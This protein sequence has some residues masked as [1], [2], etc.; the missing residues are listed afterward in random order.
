MIINRLFTLIL[1]SGQVVMAQTQIE[2]GNFETWDNSTS[3]EQEP[4][5]WSSLKTSDDDSFLNLA[6]QAPQVI[7]KETTDPHSGNACI[8]LKVASYNALV[9]I[10]PNAI[11]TNGRVFASTTPSDGYVFTDAS[12]TEWNTTCSDKPDSLI[13]WYKYAPQSNDKGRIEVLFH[14]TAHQGELPAYSNYT[15][16]VGNGRTEFTT[17]KSSWT[18]FSFPINYSTSIL[19]THFL[20]ISS[21]GDA[22]NA[23]EN[24]QLSL[25]DMSFIYNPPAGIN[26]SK[27]VNH[28]IYAYNS[29]INV[30]LDEEF[31]TATIKLYSLDGKLI[32]N[33]VIEDNIGKIQTQLSSGMYIYQLN[34]DG[35]IISGKISW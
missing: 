21:A 5:Q 12:N 23:Q 19:P 15:H 27:E 16:W 25:D 26:E 4:S 35:E 29:E 28:T 13:G 3:V 31:N 11:V 18:R 32:M 17:S 30:E 6:N 33:E 1:L 10:A 7:W 2:N 8:K 9:G 20:I 22:L 34:I 24:S 14:T